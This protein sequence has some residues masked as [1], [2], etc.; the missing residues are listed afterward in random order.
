MKNIK[1]FLFACLVS[2]IIIPIGIVWNIGKSILS[3]INYWVNVFYQSFIAVSYLF[4]NISKN[5]FY[6]LA[7]VQDLLW[8]ALAGEFLEDIFTPIE[9]NTAFGKGKLTISSAIG[10]Q[11]ERGKLSNIGWWFSGVLNSFFN[12][13]NHCLESWNKQKHLYKK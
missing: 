6:N 11:L 8:N 13:D 4:K 12:E 5:V 9:E 7:Y 10:R 2:V 1:F 3:L